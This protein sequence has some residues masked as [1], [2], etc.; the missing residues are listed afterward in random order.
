MAKTIVG[1]FDNFNDAENVVRDLENANF[2]KNDIS[3]V[4]NQT[5]H[6]ATTGGATTGG[7]TTGTGG[8]QTGTGA[9]HGAEAGAV[10]GGVTGLLV[11]LGALA[12]PGIGP[13]LAA[14]PLAAA[15]GTTLGATATGAAIGAVGGGLIGALTHAG[16]PK[17]EA[18]YYTEGVRRGGTLVTVNSPDDRAQE[19][20]DIMNGRG[21]VDIDSR[22]STY[23][24]TGYTGYTPDAAPYAHEDIVAERNRYAGTTGAGTTGTANVAGETVIPIVEEELTVGKRQVQGGGARVHTYMTETP[25]QESVTLREERVTV[26]R[27]P[28][29]RAVTDADKTAFR[30][31]TTEVT[32]TSEVP[33]VAK[34]ARVVEEVVV[35]KQA[36]ERTETVKDTVRRTEVDVEDVNTGKSGTGNR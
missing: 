27:R 19:A 14:G 7:A 17:E 11:G 1:L 18:Q 16:V 9:A 23:Q 32:E 4:A 12:I 8:T 26:D 24:E 6:A 30:E 25:V 31:G 28:V 22:G 36:T 15:L 29:D 3:I 21:A 34:E 13:V 20:V 5:A 33:V 2:A 10:I 35:G